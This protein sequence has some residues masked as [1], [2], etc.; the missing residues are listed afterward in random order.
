MLHDGKGSEI[1]LALLSHCRPR[2]KVDEIT[3]TT[4]QGRKK[5]KWKRILSERNLNTFRT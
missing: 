2:K 5:E 3:S 4:F 1:P